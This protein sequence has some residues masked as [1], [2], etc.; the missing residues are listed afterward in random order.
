MKYDGKLKPLLLNCKKNI[1][2]LILAALI[3]CLIFL[4]KIE[5]DRYLEEE[6]LIEQDTIVKKENDNE[7]PVEYH[8]VQGLNG[9][10]TYSCIQT[11]SSNCGFGCEVC[12]M[13]GESFNRPPR[14]CFD[15]PQ[16]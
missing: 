1:I 7:Q 6:S 2:F 5:A 8:V 11:C 9:I 16:V 3:L 13:N 14:C 4:I 12:L 10:Y 15:Y